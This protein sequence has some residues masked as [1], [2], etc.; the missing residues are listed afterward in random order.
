MTRTALES[1][2]FTVDGNDPSQHCRCAVDQQQS[3]IYEHCNKPEL[4]M[5]F[6]RRLRIIPIELREIIAAALDRGE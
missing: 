3:Y 5:N 4:H 6:I 1:P 2:L